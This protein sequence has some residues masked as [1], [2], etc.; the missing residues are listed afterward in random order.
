[1]TRFRP[2]NSNELKHGGKD[3]V[4]FSV[5]GEQH[6]VRINVL[7]RSLF[8]FCLSV[9]LSLSLSL[10]IV[11]DPVDLCFFFFVACHLFSICLVYPRFNFS[12][13][14]SLSCI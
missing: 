14:L 4:E 5:D 9:C 3:G 13:S 2:S 6:A 7:Y 11:S 10:S 1:M 8:V 12:L